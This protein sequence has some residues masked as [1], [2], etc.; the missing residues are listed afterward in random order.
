MKS[1]SKSLLVGSI[2]V[3]HQ[4][5]AFADVPITQ[6][7]YDEYVD[8]IY[9]AFMVPS[10]VKDKCV[11]IYPEL[12]EKMGTNLAQWEAHNQERI[13]EITRQWH[14]LATRSPTKIVDGRPVDRRLEMATRIVSFPSNIISTIGGERD[15]QFR[16]SCFNFS[17]YALGNFELNPLRGREILLMNFALCE[18]M[19]LCSG[20]QRPASNVSTRKQRHN[21]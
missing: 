8:L 12:K 14:A 1:A 3:L 18:N 10:H 6:E 11:A 5:T 7:K 2:L 15:T 21:R 4:L 13:D 20:I 9:W 17:D 16:E 19:N